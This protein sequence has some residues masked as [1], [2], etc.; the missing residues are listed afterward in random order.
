MFFVPTLILAQVD[1]E[2]EGSKIGVYLASWIP[3]LLLFGILFWIVRSCH[4][5]LARQN[6]H[7]ERVDKALDRQ[8]LHMERVE[9]QL[10]RLAG[11][12][13]NLRTK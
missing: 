12:L 2:P 9:M 11:L 3:M 4:K 8:Y 10:D 13:E 7:M 6:L 5:T 1:D